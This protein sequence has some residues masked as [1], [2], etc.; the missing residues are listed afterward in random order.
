MRYTGYDNDNDKDNDNGDASKWTYRDGITYKRKR[1][2]FCLFWLIIS[3]LN[4]QMIYL[5][6]LMMYKG[7][8]YVYNIMGKTELQ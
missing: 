7:F 6:I 2:L 4:D 5:I 1:V 3:Q 8:I